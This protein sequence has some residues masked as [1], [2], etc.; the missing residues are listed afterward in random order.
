MLQLDN[1]IIYLLGTIILLLIYVCVFIARKD[2]RKIML[3]SSTV[4]L[5]FGPLTEIF[6]FKD[7]W[8]PPSF[9]EIHILGIKVLPEDIFYAF[10][11]PVL[12][13]FLY[14]LIF[15]IKLNGTI[16]NIKI[17][18]LKFYILAFGFMVLFTGITLITKINSI[19]SC[20]ISA[21][22]ISIVILYKRKDLIETFLKTAITAAPITFIA[23]Y[24][25]LLIFGNTYL[26]SVWLLNPKVYGLYFLGADI[27]LTEVMFSLFVF[28]F[29]GVLILFSTNLKQ[30]TPP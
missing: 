13:G 9:L 19:F 6:F 16:A 21:S 29:V 8:F 3:I 14:I 12:G 22:I 30:Q 1:K 23:Y 4:I 17:F 26:Y 10:T 5:P 11:A 7:Y 27:P 18:L 2:L 25:C 20:T 28:P 15:N 24:L